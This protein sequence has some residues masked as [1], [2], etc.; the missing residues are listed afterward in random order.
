M[1]DQSSAVATAGEKQLTPAQE[2]RKKINEAK[3]AIRIKFGDYLPKGADPTR[4]YKQWKGSI[5]AADPE[6]VDDQVMLFVLGQAK[7]AGIDPTV[8]KQI[9]ALP[10]NTKVKDE[11]GKPTGEWATKFNIVIGIEGMVTIAENTGQYGGTTR[12]E[13]EFDPDNGKLI[14]C[15]IGVHKVVQGILVTSEQTV[16][17]DEYDT[18]KNLWASKPKTMLKKVAH[19]HALRAAFSATKGLNIAEELERDDV[20]DVDSTGKVI[21]TYSTGDIQKAVKACKTLDDLQKYYDGLSYTDKQKAQSMVND[22]F[23]ELAG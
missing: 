23:S 13:Y 16:Y 8:P 11:H 18:G 19:A 10:F 12:P 15:T 1:T 2:Q 6:K 14:S 5:F 17:M 4:I 22:R 7:A 3:R 21:P 9:Y 20:I